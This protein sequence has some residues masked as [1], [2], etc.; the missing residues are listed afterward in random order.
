MVPIDVPPL[1][2]PRNSQDKHHREP[3]RRPFKKEAHIESNGLTSQSA[4]RTKIKLWVSLK[5]IVSA[6]RS[7]FLWKLTEHLVSL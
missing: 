3:L 5:E 7:S 6:R 2:A 4:K 1:P